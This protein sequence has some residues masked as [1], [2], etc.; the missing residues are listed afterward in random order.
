MFSRR[1]PLLFSFLV[2]TAL[3]SAS[4]IFLSLIFA[5]GMRGSEMAGLDMSSGEKVGVIEIAGVIANSRDTLEQLKRFREDEDIKAI[6]IRVDSPGGVVGPSQ[7]IY[8]EVLRTRSTKKVIASMG[9]VAAS[10]GYYVIAGADGIVANPGTITGSIGVIMEYTNFQELFQKIGL[11]PVV[12]KSGKFKDAGS[13]VRK[14]TP[15]E[16]RILKNFV[17]R[18]HQQFVSAI[19]EGRQMDLETVQKLAD[20]R[21]YTGADAKEIG[22]VDRIGNLEDAIEWAGQLAGIE[23]D[24]VPVY[25]PAKKLS[26]MRLL[27]E[28]LLGDLIGRVTHQEMTAEYRYTPSHP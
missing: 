26:V 27:T 13:P 4:L 8:R 22:L 23:G 28:S 11:S 18:L 19:A 24:I 16:E 14:M 7:E 10:G 1:H 3:I 20:G 17:D 6:V 5:F 15:E 25:P 9:A 12:I 21:I 2:F